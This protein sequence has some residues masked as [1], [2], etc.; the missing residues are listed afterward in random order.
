MNFAQAATSEQSAPVTLG[1]C[2]TLA[3]IWEATAP[4]P[5]NVY[6]GADFDDLTYTDFL[7]SAAVI[8]PILQRVAEQGVGG[9]ILRAAEATQQAVGTNTNLGILLLLTP[10]AAV[11]SGKSLKEVSSEVLERLTLTDSQHVYAAIRLAQPGGLGNVETGDVHSQHEPALPFLEAMQLAADRDLVARQF[12]N[13]FQEVFLVAD[14]I[15][16]GLGFGWCLSDAIVRAFV[17]LL[18]AHPDSLIARKCG[19]ELAEDVSLRAR[20]VLTTGQ[21]GDDD[22]QRALQDLDFWLRADGHRRNPGTSADLAAA[23]LFV[24]LREQ[25]LDWPVR[26]Y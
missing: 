23:G 15:Q 18:A 10:L 24:L 22:Y 4:K 16:N 25:R 13:G 3:C 5:G 8:G 14:W 19:R 26:F 1:D 20:A 6:R 12:G 21:V 7:T 2:A 9:T 11:P 17:Q